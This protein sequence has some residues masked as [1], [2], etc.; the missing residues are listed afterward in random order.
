MGDEHCRR[1]QISSARVE[2]N[3]LPGQFFID[4]V[5]EAAVEAIRSQQCNRHC[6]LEFFANSGKLLRPN[7]SRNKKIEVGWVDVADGNNA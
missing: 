6:G 3:L 7:Q 5:D 4:L 1:P 2:R